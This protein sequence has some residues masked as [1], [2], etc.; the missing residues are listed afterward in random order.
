MAAGMQVRK[1]W[2]L[3]NQYWPSVDTYDELRRNNPWWLV[4]TEFGIVEIG[5]RKRVYS[6][7]WSETSVRGIVTEDDVT[8]DETMVH[9]YTMADLLTYLLELQKLSF[10]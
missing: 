10:E 2:K 3:E 1:M 6:V 7:D 5:K 9:A 4:K 8:K